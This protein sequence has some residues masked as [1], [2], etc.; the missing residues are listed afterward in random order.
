M[1]NPHAEFCKACKRPYTEAEKAARLAERR[2]NMEAS[3]LKAIA[4]GH[5]PGRKRVGDRELIRKLREQGYS[6]R[7]VAQLSGVSTSAVSRALQEM[8]LTGEWKHG[9]KDKK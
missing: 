9:R 5:P 2:K 6:L 1:G 3:R 7:G 8:G 4:N